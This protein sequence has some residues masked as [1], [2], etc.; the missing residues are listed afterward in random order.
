MKI[1]DLVRKYSGK[2]LGIIVDTAGEGQQHHI[3][4]Q[5]GGAS[6]GIWT[7]AKAVEV[8]SGNW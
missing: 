8:V 1:G 5:W 6:G 2:R 4:V 7:S 3:K